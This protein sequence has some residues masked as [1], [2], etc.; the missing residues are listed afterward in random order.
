[1]PDSVADPTVLGDHES[2]SEVKLSDAYGVTSPEENR[3]LYE[4]WAGSYDTE[5]ADRHGYDYHNQVS[6]VFLRAGG[7][8]DLVLDVGCGTGLVGSALR[9]R[10]VRA[11]HGLDLSPAMLAEAA[12]KKTVE[13]D[14]VYTHLEEADLTATVD[15]PDETYPGLVT[16]GTFTHGHLGPDSLHEVVRMCTPG[17]LLAIGVNAEL[18]QTEGGFAEWMAAAQSD[19][20][21]RDAGTTTVSVYAEATLGAAGEEDLGSGNATGT[22]ML[23]RKV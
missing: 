1:M 2:M 18:F 17:A 20:L 16:A 22:V 10:G 5:F 19:G 7:S 15:V 4:R 8:T 21:I 11:V 23:F 6:E 9:E 12:E 13:G 14:P 3:E